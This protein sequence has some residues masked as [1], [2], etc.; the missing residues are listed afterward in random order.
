MYSVNHIYKPEENLNYLEVKTSNKDT[1]ALIQLNEGASLQKLTINNF[2]LIEDLNPLD[3]ANTYASSILFPFANRI[4]DGNYSFND[5]NYQLA[6]N[7]VDRN[8]ALHGLVYNKTFE[9]LDKKSNESFASVK[10]IYHEENQSIGFPFIY[11]I[12]LEYI[13]NKSKLDLKVTVTNTGSKSFPFTLGWHPYFVS[14]KL[15]E[16]VLKFESFEK[17]V[18]DDRMITKKTEDIETSYLNLDVE[19][20]DDCWVL[21]DTEVFFET[22]EYNLHIL[23]SEKN[24]FLQTYIPPRKNTIAIEPT[25]GVSDSFNNK[26]GLQ[27]LNPK[28]TYKLTWTLKL[29]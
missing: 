15:S 21:D 4:K 19:N 26:I 18:F 16:S 23:S 7:E 6:I 28:E 3:Y 5:T 22:P 24:S 29:D 10:L 20:L 11:K 12:E 2:D 8:H 27:T 14:K 25:T 17:L 9:V 1:Y 13:F